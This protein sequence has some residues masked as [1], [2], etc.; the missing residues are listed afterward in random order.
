MMRFRRASKETGSPAPSQDAAAVSNAEKARALLAM[1]DGNGGATPPPDRLRAW[2]RDLVNTVEQ[3]KAATPT[4]PGGA[5]RSAPAADVV[6]APQPTAYAK[7]PAR[8]FSKAAPLQAPPPAAPP[9]PAVT[10]QPSSRLT[11]TVPEPHVP[12]APASEA[13]MPPVRVAPAE[14][15]KIMEQ[16]INPADI[17]REHPAIIARTLAGKTSLEQAAAL[18]RLPGGQVRA[19][20]RALRQLEQSCP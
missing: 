12:R 18:R 7:P 11:L 17:G 10:R 9:P 14:M 8:V 13:P 19:V 1:L 15:D 16:A 3:R 20:H 6:Q 4:A 5:P 2:A